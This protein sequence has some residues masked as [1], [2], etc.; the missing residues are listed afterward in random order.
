MEII[1][2]TLVSIFIQI[3]VFLGWST[4]EIDRLFGE[5]YSEYIELPKSNLIE[6]PETLKKLDVPSDKNNTVIQVQKK[7]VSAPTAQTITTPIQS[8]TTQSTTNTNSLLQNKT[9]TAPKEILKQATANILCSER[10][11]NL[12][13]K[14]TGSAVAVSNSGIL[15]TNAHVGQYFLLEKYLGKEQI[16]CYVRTGSPAQKKYTA[17]IIYIPKKWILS[18]KDNL[19]N[20]NTSDTGEN[21]FAILSLKETISNSADNLNHLSFIEYSAKKGDTAIISGYPLKNSTNP[22]IGLYQLLDEVKFDGVWNLGTTSSGLFQTTTTYL[23]SNGASG[24][25]IIDINGKLIGLIFAT[26]N[27]G[28]GV[29][30]VLGITTNHIENVLQDE[31]GKNLIEIIKD[32]K[33]EAIEF[34]PTALNYA[35]I[36][37]NK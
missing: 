29:N 9:L 1:S 26:S 4:Q 21:D 8:T 28:G 36:L 24:G 2:K 6:I 18:H 27:T 15:L 14:I 32:A 37:L 34:A 30:K 13:K 3:S 5:G 16:Y 33:D 22:E 19:T 20:L 12:E 17:E 31:T 35:K 7:T 23:A 11:G 10:I 25:G